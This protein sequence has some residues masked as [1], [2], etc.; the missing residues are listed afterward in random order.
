MARFS[1][2]EVTSNRAIAAIAIAPLQS[3]FSDPA[4]PGK[5]QYLHVDLHRLALLWQIVDFAAIYRI[6]E[7][8]VQ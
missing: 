4:E 1:N 5:R 8:I 2:E 7:S 3:Q 6:P